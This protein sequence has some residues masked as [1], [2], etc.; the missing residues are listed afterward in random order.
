MADVQVHTEITPNPSTLKFVV[1]CSLGVTRPLSVPDLETAQEKSPLAAKLFG[2]AGVISVFIG[3][4]FISVTKSSEVPWPQLSTSVA[5]AIQTHMQAGL[6]VLTTV[7]EGA[8][9]SAQG[10]SQIERRIV[11]LIETQIAPAVAMDGGSIVFHGFE[12][13]IVKLEMQG[14]CSGCP[15]SSATLKL[16]IENLLRE[17]IPEVQSVEQVFSEPHFHF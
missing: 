8:P 4:D 5:G 10:Q 1:D 11:E 16:G 15:S 3:R 14:S 13:G 2:C 17:E 7:P 12:D 6:A 9:L